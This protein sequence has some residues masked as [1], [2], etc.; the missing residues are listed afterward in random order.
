M[1]W[2]VEYTDEF[3]A[4]YGGL[5]EAVQDDIDRVVGLLEARGPQLPFPYS[6]GIE[7]SRHPR[8][9]ELRIQSGG[10]PYRVF[11]AFDLRRTAILLIG[12]NKG[13]DDRFYDTMIPLADGLYDAYLKEI[14]KEGLI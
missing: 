7:G 6:S 11:Y 14:G 4:W 12:G 3:G 1:N 5:S 8:M 10:E 13:G 9:R 2:N